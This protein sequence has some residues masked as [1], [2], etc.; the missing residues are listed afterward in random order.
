MLLPVS[1]RQACVDDRNFILSSWL[2]S[3]RYSSAA[4]K[5][6]NDIYFSERGQEGLC[7]RLLSNCHTVIACDRDE[8]EQIYGWMCWRPGVLHF[9]LVK[10]IYRGHGLLSAMFDVARLGQKEPLVVTHY[11]RPASRW[12]ERRTVIYNPYLLLE[13]S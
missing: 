3:Y 8:P 6:P 5:V 11:T 1:Y 12:R 2:R 9:T 7:K 13:E 10:S 4:T